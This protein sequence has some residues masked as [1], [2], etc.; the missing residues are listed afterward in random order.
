MQE[1]CT[2][3]ELG[4][5]LN[6][7]PQEAN[8][9]ADSLANLGVNQSRPIVFF[10]YASNFMYSVLLEDIGGVAWPRQVRINKTA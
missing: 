8:R 5:I 3:W 6:P 1:A 2:G 9:A 7:L 4:D 10:D